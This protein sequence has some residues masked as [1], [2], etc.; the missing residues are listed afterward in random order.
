MEAIPFFLNNVFIYILIQIIYGMLIWN[1]NFINFLEYWYFITNGKCLCVDCVK[2]ICVSIHRLLEFLQCQ[3]Y[4]IQFVEMLLA[5]LMPIYIRK[6]KKF[7]GFVPF[8]SVIWKKDLFLKTRLSFSRGSIWFWTW[9]NPFII[10][11]FNYL[12]TAYLVESE[13]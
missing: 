7:S 4:I 5:A 10:E 9:D 2:I 13:F 11:H 8:Y 1:K 6:W 12:A 3:K